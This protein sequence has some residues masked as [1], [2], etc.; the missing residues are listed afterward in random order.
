MK[1]TA[2]SQALRLLRARRGGGRRDRRAAEAL[3]GRRGLTDH[4]LRPGGR[5]ST[6]SPHRPPPGTR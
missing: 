6:Q 4:P 2:V 1:D 3:H 5:R